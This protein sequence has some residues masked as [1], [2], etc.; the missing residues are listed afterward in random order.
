MLLLLLQTFAWMTL[1]FLLGAT[2][3]CLARSTFGARSE[4]GLVPARAAA[5]TG[6]AITAR[7]A[8][9]PVA[10]GP[11]IEAVNA[12]RP[13]TPP[14]PATVPA[15]ARTA[16]TPYTYPITTVGIPRGTPEAI[17]PQIQKI[18]LTPAAATAAP[19]TVTIKTADAAT[20]GAPEIGRAHV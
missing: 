4:S 13:V 1:V 2:L 8:P 16:A 17:Q 10:R 3:G 11:M 6:A 15:A 5:A 9:A 18:G 12:P 20:P 19:A 14:A 7:S